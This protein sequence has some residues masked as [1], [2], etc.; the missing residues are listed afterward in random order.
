MEIEDIG[1]IF[2]IQGHSVHDGPGART[3]VFLKGCHLNCSWC[4]N[5]EGQHPYPE[6]MYNHDKCISDNLCVNACHLNAITSS[7]KTLFFDKNKCKECHEF[8][9]EYVCCSSAIK[10]AGREISINELMAR[11]KKDRLFWGDS[12]G[13]TFTGGEPLLQ[14]NFLLKILK[15][16]YDSYIHTTV[17][18][19]GYASSSQMRGI[20]PYTDWIFFDIKHMNR[21]K[22]LKYTGVDNAKIINNAKIT[23]SEFKG[24]LIF[25]MVIVPGFN[26]SESEIIEF[27]DFINSLNLTEKEVNLL[28]IHHMGISKYK[29][30]ELK[31]YA[32]NLPKITAAR[33]KTLADILISKKINCYIGADTPF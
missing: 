24:R 18:T 19:C 10:I 9:C 20:F 7:N 12:G 26:D 16:C 28:P 17:E 30:L 14:Y 33:L 5:P 6:P 2:D 27:A 31:Y 1:V 22:H 25:R 4:S 13:V 11:I 3:L 32:D 15:K 21:E 29:M 8:K 23:A